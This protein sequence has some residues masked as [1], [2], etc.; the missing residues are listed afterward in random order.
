MTV[1]GADHQ[2]AMSASVCFTLGVLLL[3][4]VR[5]RG[6]HAEAHVA[7][8]AAVRLLPRV[9]PHVVLQGRVGSELCAALVAGKRLLVKVFGAL[10]VNHPWNQTRWRLKD[11]CLKGNVCV[12][13]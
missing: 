6:G 1:T 10:V 2:G 13:V 3:G 4:V 8:F 11:T 12:S 9:Q 7:V 5:E